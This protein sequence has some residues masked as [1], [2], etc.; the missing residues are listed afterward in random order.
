MGFAEDDDMVEAVAANGAN[1]ALHEWILPWRVRRGLDLF[2]A[3]TGDAPA[4]PAQNAR[5]C[6]SIGLVSDLCN[7][8][9]PRMVPEKGIEPL[10][11]CD[12]GILSPGQDCPY[13]SLQHR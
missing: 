2:D 3:K 9:I 12:H 11:S 6:G 1:Q 13:T 10:R 7:L 5:I 4:K 8:L